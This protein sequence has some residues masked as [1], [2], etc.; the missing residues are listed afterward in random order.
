V[1]GYLSL[2]DIGLGR[3]LTIEI[4]RDHGES[5]RRHLSNSAW[6]L[7][8]LLFG[9]GCLGGVLIASN[10]SPLVDFLRISPSLRDE[11]VGCLW[12][13]AATLPLVTVS[14]GM[15]GILEGF[16]AFKVVS[17]LRAVHG[18]ITF[19][20]P[21]VL[22]PMSRTLTSLMAGLV[23]GRLITCLIS[24]ALCVH[25]LPP[26]RSNRGEGIVPA[27]RTLKLGGWITISNLV[28]PVL[29]SAYRFIIGALTS[30]SAVALYATPFEFATK[31]LILPGAFSGV[32]LPRFAG[33]HR[34]SSSV[35]Q[36]YNSATLVLAG[37]LLVATGSL[38][39]LAHPTLSFWLGASLAD[40]TYRVLQILCI[41][42]FLNGVANIPFTLLQASG[43]PDLTAKLHLV[44][45]PF[46]LVMA[47]ILIARFGLEGAASAWVVRVAVDLVALIFLSRRLLRTSS[48]SP[49]VAEVSAIA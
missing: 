12:L 34:N 8:A 17:V 48:V 32:L 27:V 26:Q 21:L 45:L 9:L 2:F 22:L 40:Q 44:E 13:V 7:I 18:T 24:L 25:R 49:R 4:A 41:G 5:S 14:S 29:V 46:Y 33:R 16:R 31:L 11:A 23:A 38:A 19:A 47:T 3:A 36:L 37:L 6:T 35:S 43:R 28:S 39:L 10:A 30:T 15:R 20:L 1:I 42:I